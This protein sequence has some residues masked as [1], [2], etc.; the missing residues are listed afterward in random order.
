MCPP[1]IIDPKGDL[2]NLVLHFPNLLPTD[3][4]PWVDPDAARKAGKTTT[5]LAEDTATNLEDKVWPAGEL[6]GTGIAKLD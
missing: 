3:F 1:I 5:G 6:V 4:E 2:T